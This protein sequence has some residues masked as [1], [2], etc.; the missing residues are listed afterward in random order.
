VAA[1]AALAAVLLAGCAEFLATPAG[2]ARL[3]LALQPVAQT[4]QDSAF[5]AVDGLSVRVYRGEEVVME[6]SFAVS[7][8]GGVIRQ[9]IVVP[10]EGDQESLDLFVELHAGRQTVFAGDAVLRLVRGGRTTVE[11]DLVPVGRVGLGAGVDDATAALA[12]AT[13]PPRRAADVRA[14]DA[15]RPAH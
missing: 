7:P 6:D 13:L 4:R 9:S 14:G 8:A 12:L 15:S 3:S 10:V 1:A 5:D 11:V 2:G